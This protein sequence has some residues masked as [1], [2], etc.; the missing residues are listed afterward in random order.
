MDLMVAISIIGILATMATPVLSTYLNRARYA[1]CIADIKVIESALSRYLV[2]KDT[3]PDTLAQVNLAGLTDPWGQPFVYLKIDGADLSINGLV[4]KDKFM[5]PINSD[6]DLYSKGP[7]GESVPP[8][9][10]RQSLDDIIRAN[11]GSYVGRAA[12]Y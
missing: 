7:D 11:D 4:R 6:F 2:K 3:Y 1:R 9:T 8:L 12:G 5:V 10:A